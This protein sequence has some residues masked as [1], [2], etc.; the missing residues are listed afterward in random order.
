MWKPEIFFPLLLISTGCLVHRTQGFALD[1]I[2]DITKIAKD[3]VYVISKAWNIVESNVDFGEIPLPLIDRTE[4]KL[5][6]KIG[7]INTKVDLI[8]QQIDITGMYNVLFFFT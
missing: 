6:Q 7:L 5:F 8:A 2:L 3:I 1:N 4:R